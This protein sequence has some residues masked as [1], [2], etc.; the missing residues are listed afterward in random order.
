M[1]TH[2]ETIHVNYMAL[3]S[4]I[5]QLKILSF[6]NNISKGDI[7]L[8]VDCDPCPSYIKWKE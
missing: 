8:R 6:M 5:L 1:I 4:L 7:P 2:W 3:S